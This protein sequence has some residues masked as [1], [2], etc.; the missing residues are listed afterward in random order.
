MAFQPEGYRTVNYKKNH[1]SSQFIKLY[2]N[3]FADRCTDFIELMGILE[4][5]TSREV[6]Q[7]QP[8]SRP[9]LPSETH[10]S[11]KLPVVYK[12]CQEDR[13][14]HGVVHIRNPCLR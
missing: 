4:R 11:C 6:I 3:L 13:C 14:H 8:I 5:K 9:S 10:V 7:A 1:I 12:T 2:V